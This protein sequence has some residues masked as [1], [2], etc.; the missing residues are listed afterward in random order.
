M[1][2]E[3]TKIESVGLAPE[4]F[5][6]VAAHAAVHPAS[7]VHG[8]LVGSREGGRISV[9]GA[10]PVCHETPTG[11]LVETALSLVQSSL[12]EDTS[13]ETTTEIVGWFTAPELLHEKA[14]GPVAL[15][16]VASLAAATSGGGTDPV[17]LVVDNEALLALAGGGGAVLASEAVRAFGK[18]LGRQWKEPVGSL[19]VESDAG[20]AEAAASAIREATG[21][22]AGPFVRDLV[23]HWKAGAASEWTTAASLAAFTKKHT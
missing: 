20:A 22:A 19:A 17:L 13:N 15:R 7:P 5:V 11:V 23:D 4:V 3:G 9:H 10:Y 21:A 14:P 6:L 18:D 2:D 12:E 8:V 1:A 16:I